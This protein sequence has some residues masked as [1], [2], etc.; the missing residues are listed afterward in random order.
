M[1]TLP[2]LILLA[3][4]A[5]VAGAHAWELDAKALRRVEA[6][7]PY[8]MV[9]A[10]DG[11]V[12]GLIRGAI[13]IAAPPQVVWRV[14]IDCDLAPRMVANL[15]SCRI[16]ERDPHGAWDVREHIS[17]ANLVPSVRSVFRSE[18]DPQRLL[19][20]FYRVDGDLRRLDGQ[21]RLIP[22]EGGQRTRVLYENHAELPFRAPKML[23]RMGLR[24]D[25]PA[26]LLAL[27][28]ECLARLDQAG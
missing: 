23:V 24:R 13:D 1:R 15:K 12:G 3:L 20:T 14:V 18:Y 19:V 7:R 28:R 8:V 2:A 25:V 17:R 10:E 27:R 5:P 22:L 11:N 6:G 9:S 4:A 21:W 16:L 26:A